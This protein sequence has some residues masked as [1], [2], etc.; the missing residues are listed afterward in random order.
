MY[1]KAAECY[2]I[3]GKGYETEAAAALYS[4][5]SAFV[6]AGLTGDAKATAKLLKSLYPESKQANKVDALIK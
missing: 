5:S 2:R 1:L 3:C 6:S 4:A